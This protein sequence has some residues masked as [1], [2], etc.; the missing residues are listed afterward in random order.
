MLI[1]LHQTSPR[2][3]ETSVPQSDPS[4]SPFLNFQPLLS[5]FF[6]LN[7]YKNLIPTIH[8]PLL[9][10]SPSGLGIGIMS[11]CDVSSTMRMLTKLYLITTDIERGLVFL[12]FWLQSITA[13]SFA[14]SDSFCECSPNSQVVQSSGSGGGA[15]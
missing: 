8:L 4:I 9:L 5:W 13:H 11:T 1:H 3:G 6:T 12:S 15:A 10:E 7:I 14:K 2:H